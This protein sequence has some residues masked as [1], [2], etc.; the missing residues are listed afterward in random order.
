MG[1]YPI[2]KRVID[3]RS[4]RGYSYG[5]SSVSYGGGN[6]GGNSY[7]AGSVGGASYGSGGAQGSFW[8]IILNIYKFNYS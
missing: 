7:D 5:A 8:I 3:D 2:L 6:V 1:D 4:D